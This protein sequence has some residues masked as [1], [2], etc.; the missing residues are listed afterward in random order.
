MKK[1]AAKCY[2]CEYASSSFK[3]GKLTHLNCEDPE[4]YTE[5]KYNNDEFCAWDTLTE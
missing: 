4:K 1:K 3:I 2:N 5:E